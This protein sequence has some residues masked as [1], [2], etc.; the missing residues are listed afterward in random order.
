M[1]KRVFIAMGIILI[2]I[3]LSILAVGITLLIWSPGKIDP[4]VDEN[5]TKLAGS[6]SEITRVSI[7]GAEQGLI[8]KGKSDKN[9]VLLF[10]HGGP[11]SPEYVLAKN[12]N[13]GL[14]DYF[15]VCWWDQRGSGMS[16]LSTNDSAT[17]T[18]EQMVSDTVEVTNYL[19]Q[20]FGQEKIYIM[21]HSWGTFLG[22]NVVSRY[23]KRY[24]AYIGMGQISN[25]LESEKLGYEHML[26]TARSNGD[27]K[28]EQKLMKYTLT[29]A[30]S[31]TMDYL[32]LRSAGMNKQGNG[33][34]HNIKSQFK[35]L[36]LPILQAKEYTLKDKY[37]YF[38]G[39]LFSLKQVNDSIYTVNL[40]E[41]I[42][43]VEIPVY[44]MHGVYD[45]QVSYQLSKEYFDLLEA[46]KKQFFTFE[47]SAHSP[48]MEEPEQFMEIML[49]H[50]IGGEGEQ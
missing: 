18:F 46:P 14:E 2:I 26:L 22:L 45:K 1:Q 49:A 41:E 9:P 19:S 35:D 13:T 11:G 16:Y 33:I 36:L 48:L 20:R 25:Q 23:P 31:I 44:I 7:G 4:Y 38:M 10:L 17:M 6:I 32:M 42:K 40:M 3:V 15:T 24:E 39:S 12:Y 8:I 37:G 5:G 27:R 43:K 21:G 50:I 29:D 28:L 34:Y 47:N 30:K